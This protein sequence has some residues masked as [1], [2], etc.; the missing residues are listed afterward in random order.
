MELCGVAETARIYVDG[1]H[2][3]EYVLNDFFLADKLLSIG[4]VV[5]F[6]DAGW[7]SV[8][9]VIRFLGRY[10]K[11]CE[12][13]VGLSR[14][15]RSR[16]MLFSLVRRIEGRCTNDRYFEKLSDWEPEQGFYRAF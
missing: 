5:G 15:Y 11:Y 16:N 4:G 2:N 7:R 8:Y 10:R 6:N 13:N 3:F 14:V 9:K 1:N 12:L